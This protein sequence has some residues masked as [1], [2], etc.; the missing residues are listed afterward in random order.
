MI[1]KTDTGVE[2]FT[3]TLVG[4]GFFSVFLVNFL[5]LVLDDSLDLLVVALSSADNLRVRDLDANLFLYLLRLQAGDVDADL[6]GERLAVLGGQVHA[7]HLVLGDGDGDRPVLA[8]GPRSLSTNFTR[9]LKNKM[10]INQPKPAP[11]LPA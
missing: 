4:R 11:C 6:L 8:Y 9:S 10:F 3:S 1:N 2:E 7:H 5:L